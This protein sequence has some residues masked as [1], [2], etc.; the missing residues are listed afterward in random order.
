MIH[1]DSPLTNRFREVVGQ[2]SSLERAVQRVY[3]TFV[4]GY[5]RFYTWYHFGRRHRAPIDPLEI[6][7]INPGEIVGKQQHKSEFPHPDPISE[8]RDGSWDQDYVRIEDHHMFQSFRQHFEGDRQWAET[9]FYRECIDGIR[10]GEVKW[11]CA[12]IEAFEERLD[13]IDGLYEVIATTGY[14]SQLE[15]HQEKDRIARDIHGYW[16]AP[17]NEVT[18]NIGRGGD[19]ILHDGRHRLFIARL[20]GIE[21]IPVRVKARH[22]E[23][24]T[25]RDRHAADTIGGGAHPDLP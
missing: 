3:P 19:F 23:W 13:T 8:V 6:L 12:T 9:P 1:P 10:T 11:G 25:L 14:R 7:H 20:V 5:A 21:A 22:L 2:Y 15:L 18:T 17:L 16:P 4:T 24:Q